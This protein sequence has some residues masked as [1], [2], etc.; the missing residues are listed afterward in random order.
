MSMIDT[1]VL[2]TWAN[3]TL[4]LS[5]LPPTLK[6]ILDSLSP[7]HQAIYQTCKAEDQY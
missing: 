3:T 6:S 7:F 5:W 4:T 2:E 1:D